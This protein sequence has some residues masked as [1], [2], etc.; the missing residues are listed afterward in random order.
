MIA[1]TDVHTIVERED[2]IRRPTQASLPQRLAVRHVQGNDA[3][4]R[5]PLSV[6]VF[7][8]AASAS[9]FMGTMQIKVTNNS[10]DVVRVPYWQLPGSDEAKSFQVTRD[11]K[12]VDYLG[13]IV[14]DRKSVV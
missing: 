2:L 7:A 12:P 13:K 5:N 10:N 3:P 11:G 6:G 9:A 1:G 14:K 4:I 8:D